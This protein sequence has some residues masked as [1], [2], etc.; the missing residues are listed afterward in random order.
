MALG[1]PF[2]CFAFFDFNKIHSLDAFQWF[3]DVGCDSCTFKFS[4][5]SLFT[6]Y[7]YLQVYP[8]HEYLM[9]CSGN[10]KMSSSVTHKFEGIAYPV[11]KR[12]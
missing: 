4:L 1:D 11:A 10:K 8:V 2:S 5:R 9:W 7:V 3:T 12:T 6:S